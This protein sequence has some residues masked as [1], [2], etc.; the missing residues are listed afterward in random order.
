MPSFQTIVPSIVKKEQ[1]ASGLALN[2]TQ[3]N[4][5]RMLGPALAGLLMAGVGAIGCFVVSA[6]SY[7]PFIMVAL[8]ILPR[9]LASPSAPA[10][11]AG[12]PVRRL[13]WC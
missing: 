7:I 13:A 9:G 4:L 11:H 1:I 12:P 2:S 6:A 10:G 5:S 3:F 8:W